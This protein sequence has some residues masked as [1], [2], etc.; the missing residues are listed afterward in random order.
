MEVFIFY[1]LIALTVCT[2]L[3]ILFTRKVLNAALFLIVCLLAIAGIYVF[4]KADFVAVTQILVYIGGVM[5]LLVFGIMLSTKNH[6]KDTTT[7]LRR[8]IAGLTGVF[9]MSFL[10][11]IILAAD[12]S[13]KF[14]KSSVFEGKTT[15][16]IIG[17][18]IM[19]DFIFPFEIAAFIL[20][21]ALIAAAFVADKKGEVES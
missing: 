15:T 7:V 20:L 13:S 10:T 6:Q 19:T 17:K 1:F 4:A 8:I 11:H 16:H 14:S 2:G 18:Q 21:I 3:G 12:F 5:V 9:V